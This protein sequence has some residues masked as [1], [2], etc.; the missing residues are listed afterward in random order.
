MIKKLRRRLTLLFS[1]LT[2]AIFIGLTAIAWYL[3]VNQYQTN[4]N[5]AYSSEF[6]TLKNHLTT[7]NII[8]DSWLAERELTGVCIIH[9]EDGTTP[10][11]FAGSYMVGEQRKSLIKLA[12][13]EILLNSK[14]DAT[15][16]S[17]FY[18]IKDTNN[19][20]YM[21]IK[22][23]VY[24][25][26]GEMTL[27]MIKDYLPVEQHLQKSAW[28]YGG[29]ALGGCI[30]LTFA[31]HLMV[32]IATRPVQESLQQQAEFIAAASHEL[33][34][35]LTVIHAAVDAANVEEDTTKQQQLL[36]SVKREVNRLKALTDDLLLLT[37]SDAGSRA[38]NFQSFC[39]DTMLIELY[40]EFLPVCQQ[41]G[42]PF[43]LRLPDEELPMVYADSE[44]ISQ[45]ISILIQ[46]ALAYTTPGTGIELQAAV[47]RHGK[48]D[49][50]TIISVIDHGNGI[51]DTEKSQVFRR[52]Y[53][54]D[55]SRSDKT[56][57]GLGLS[58]ASEI[59]REH[60]TK[61]ELTDTPDGGAT[62][63]IILKKER[64]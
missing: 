42:Q 17:D 12:E 31:C 28:T 48:N 41:Q 40:D 4:Y 47:V 22:T 19:H 51:P 36:K 54:S 59:A 29:L 18:R 16:A 3:A 43:T 14:V 45:L 11:H 58:I 46:N 23:V 7:T 37:R 6:N 10:L 13:A 57:F 61:I 60:N 9:I 44:R 2:C 62:F 53:R 39:P 5:T 49:S 35:P 1:L 38:M 55:Q 64:L 25:S 8:R 63:Q 50:E 27:M 24:R 26:N 56:H 21:C 33:R 32:Y 15:S 52:F 30:L 34:S 20:P